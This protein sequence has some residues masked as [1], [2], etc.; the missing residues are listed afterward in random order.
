MS[1]M[2]DQRRDGNRIEWAPFIGASVEE[3]SSQVPHERGHSMGIPAGKAGK[4]AS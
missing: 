4:N 1:G 2:S 3:S